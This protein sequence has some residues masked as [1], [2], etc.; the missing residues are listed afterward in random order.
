MDANDMG[1]LV[2]INMMGFDKQTRQL[3]W[4]AAISNS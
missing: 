2:E 1:M 3:I 4:D